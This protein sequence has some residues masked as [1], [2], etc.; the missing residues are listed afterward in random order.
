SREIMKN[1]NVPIIPGSEGAVTTEKEALK[2]A[3]KLGYPVMVKASAG[4]GGIGMEIVNNDEELLDSFT[5][6]SK[7]AEAFFGSGVMF[8]EKL[9]ENARHIEFQ[10]MADQFGHVVH[11]FDRE[12]SIQRRNQKVLEEAPSSF[13]S[14]DTR[15]K[16]GE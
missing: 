9:I 11:L 14:E 16:M 8:L 12:C 13:L 7:R 15:K 1:I 2:T 3:Q 5:N 10:I 6:N 4:G